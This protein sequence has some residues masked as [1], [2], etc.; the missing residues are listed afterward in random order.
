MNNGYILNGIIDMNYKKRISTQNDQIYKY[1]K[2]INYNYNIS[3]TY[4]HF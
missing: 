3:W 1:N 4:F 2:P